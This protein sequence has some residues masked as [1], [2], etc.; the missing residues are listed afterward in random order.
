MFQMPRNSLNLCSQHILKIS[1]SIENYNLNY[2]GI[3]KVFT[4]NTF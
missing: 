3:F 1:L 4:T 2:T